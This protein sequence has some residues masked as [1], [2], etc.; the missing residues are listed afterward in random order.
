VTQLIRSAAWPEEPEPVEPGE[1]TRADH[2]RMLQRMREVWSFVNNARGYQVKAEAQAARARQAEVSGYWNSHRAIVKERWASRNGRRGETTVADIPEVAGQWHP[3]NSLPP[4][5]VAAMAQQ[6]GETSP[7]LWQC[8]LGLGHGPW[9]VWPKD[10]IQKGAGCPSCQKLVKLS[11]IPTLAG[12]Y[13]G[14]VSPDDI[15]Y[16]AHDEVPWACRTWALDPATGRWQRVEHHFE[17][18]V[19]DRSQQG[20][21]CL[22]CAGYVIDDTNSLATWFP[23]LAEQIDDPQLDP[24]RL[25]TS[26]HNV[27]R[28]SARGEDTGGVYATCYWR[29]PHGHR[30]EAT[31]LN[32]VR[33]AGCPDCSTS[34]IPKEQVRLVAELA[35]LMDLVDPG[36]PDA[37]L[38][39]GVPNFASHK[40]S[41]PARLKPAH[42]R[43][44]DVEVDARFRLC[45]H[46]VILGLEYDGVYHHSDHLRDRSGHGTEKS[47]ILAEAGAVAGVIHVRVGALP[48]LVALNALTVCVPE[49][50][51]PYEQACAVAEAITARYPGSIPKMTEYLADGRPRGQAQADAYI[52]ATWGQ[53][54]PPRQKPQRTTS[55]RQRQLQMTDPHPGSLLT[56]LGN[57]YRNPERLAEILRD[58]R[59]A[60]GTPENVTAVQSQVTSGNTR[61][62]GCLQ[63]K[64]RQQRRPA[65]ARADTQAAREWARQR[66]IQTGGNGR[67]PDRVV[68]SYRLHQAGHPE[69]LGAGKLL[70]EL[71][72]HDSS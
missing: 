70:E 12:Q 61:S 21:G 6:H 48:P 36:R 30:W 9:S 3:D 56:P 15:T 32:R 17:A 58:Y 68:S 51:T 57:P 33:G 19:K 34:G 41:I 53:L 29:C 67:L 13:R 24:S 31:I 16:G 72:G 46:Q 25:A 47:R 59:C 5:G 1:G 50:S 60:C 52:L 11:D 38:P 27:S 26:T 10:R 28:G 64:A 20:H 23:E 65:I 71:R 37:R 44:K 7:Y 63:D 49:R 45:G 35:W 8:P 66:G 2:L 42:R 4:E 55:P 14:S 40:I 43:Y 18:A 22:V 39:E 62:C 54:R 69:V